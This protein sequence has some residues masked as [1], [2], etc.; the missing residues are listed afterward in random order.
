MSEPISWVKLNRSIIKWEW[1][2]NANVKSLFLHLIL[3]ANITD[4]SYK[5]KLVRRGQVPITATGLASELGMSVQSIRTCLGKLKSS[6]EIKTTSFHDFTL[7]TVVNYELYQD[8]AEKPKGKVKKKGAKKKEKPTAPPQDEEKYL[9]Q[10]W[11]LTIPKELWGRFGTEDAYW[12]Y[13]AQ[14]GEN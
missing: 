13:A 6:G 14:G 1:Y 8:V 5:G 11:E 3:K 7:I 12:E 4:G 9:P 10:W 2:T